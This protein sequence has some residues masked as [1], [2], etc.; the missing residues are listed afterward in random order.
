MLT[1]DWMLSWTHFCQIKLLQRGTFHI[2]LLFPLQVTQI[3]Q[4]WN[5]AQFCTAAYPQ[6]VWLGILKI[7]QI[8]IQNCL[9]TNFSSCKYI[10]YALNFAQLCIPR[11]NGWAPARRNTQSDR[12]KRELSK[13][14]C[15][16]LFSDWYNEKEEVKEQYSISNRKWPKPRI[17]RTFDILF[18][19]W[20]VQIKE[21]RSCNIRS[22]K[23]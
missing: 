1:S 22:T 9:N 5:V 20:S 4:F 8:Q 14:S 17:E 3:C 2:R 7:V 21:N 15:N 6:R 10:I 23:S 19:T 12:N 18:P 13:R 11:G 16:I